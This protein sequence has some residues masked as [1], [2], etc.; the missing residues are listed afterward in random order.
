MGRL[1]D[2][3]SLDLDFFEETRPAVGIQCHLH[4]HSWLRS[5]PRWQAF[6]DHLVDRG[7]CLRAERDALL[8]YG[9]FSRQ[10]Q[11]PALLG[12]PGAARVPLGGPAAYYYSRSLDHMKLV[13]DPHAPPAATA[14]LGTVKS[15]VTRYAPTGMAG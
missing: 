3:L 14:C 7:L 13:L 10:A 11:G 1:S 15:R 6:L 2:D 5:R 8:G 12:D 4:P 9:G